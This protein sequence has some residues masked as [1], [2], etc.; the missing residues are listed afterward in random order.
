MPSTAVQ[1]Q[2]FKEFVDFAGGNG[3]TVTKELPS[4]VG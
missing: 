1:S 3:Y 2:A 4:E